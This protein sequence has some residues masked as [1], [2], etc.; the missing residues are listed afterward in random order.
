MFDSI[1]ST[2][3]ALARHHYIADAGLSTSLFLA[4][5]MEKALFL[6]GEPGVGKTEV[7]K[8]L[9]RAL[10]TPLIRLQCYEGLDLGQAVY[11]WNYPRQLL[12]IQARRDAGEGAG[13]VTRDIFG[14]EFLLKRPLL[15]AIDASHERAPVLLIDELDRADEE[16]ESFL[17]ELL[18]DFQVTV[19]EIGT[20]VAEHKPITVITSNRTREIH[21]ALKRRCVYHW[22]D[23][24]SLDKEIEIVARKVPGLS[25]RLAH[26]VVAFVQR[27]RTEDLY[28]LPGV[29]ETLDWAAALTHLSAERLEPALVESTLGFLLKYQ[30]DVDKL[31]R[32]APALLAETLGAGG[33]SPAGAPAATGSSSAAGPSAAGSAG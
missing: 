5:R 24:P 29:A 16:F 23:Y 19:P 15:Q 22:I 31:R 8:V 12:E 18:S 1:D 21:D 28:K 14:E 26:Q 4:L 10:L 9:S 25:E 27:L 11:E 32:T 13:R 2:A 30:D 17:L 20:L 6:E 33:A 7:A 3:E